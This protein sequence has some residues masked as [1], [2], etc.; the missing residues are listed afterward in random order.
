MPS[1]D[2]DGVFAHTHCSVNDILIRTK[3][4]FPANCGKEFFNRKSPKLPLQIIKADYRLI[5]Q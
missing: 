4:L 5:T 1:F 2:L 3:K